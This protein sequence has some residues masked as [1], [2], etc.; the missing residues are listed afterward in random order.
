MKVWTE[1]DPGAGDMS[2]IDSWATSVTAQAAACEEAATAL[3]SH[4]DASGDH[5]E[6]AGFLAFRESIARRVH[7]LTLMADAC[8]ESA[9][10]ATLYSGTVATIKQNTAQQQ[11]L[12]AAAREIFEN[13]VTELKDKGGP[14]FLV[15]RDARYAHAEAE[16]QIEDLALQRHEADQ[17][18]MAKV[19]GQLSGKIRVER[20]DYAPMNDDDKNKDKENARMLLALFI[21]GK[22]PRDMAFIDSAFARALADSGHMKQFR[23]KLI[24]RFKQGE[25]PVG[26]TGQTRRNLSDD[27]LTLVGDGVNAVT[28]GESGNLTET[29]VGGFLVDY[30]VVERNGSEATVTFTI[31]NDMTPESLNRVPGTDIVKMPWSQGVDFTN[32]V[33]GGY[34]STGQSVV[35]TEVI[36]IK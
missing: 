28:F 15:V 30:E 3:H 9:A 11:A 13:P 1:A 19:A 4:A 31:R 25:L 36:T 23:E 6:G 14:V 26:F 20:T 5:W 34:Q 33:L 22:A 35:W 8:R 17:T 16:K 12:A 24:E 2:V 27:Y 21:A 32:D 29:M 18:F 10:A 7:T